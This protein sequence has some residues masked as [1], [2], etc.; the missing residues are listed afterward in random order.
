MFR[1][2]SVGK[3]AG[4]VMTALAFLPTSYASEFDVKRCMNLGN[5][6]DAPSTGA[7]GHIIEQSSLKA[8]A[9][10]GFDTVRIP[11]RWN[12]R[13]G[14]GPDFFISEDFFERVVEVI[15]WALAED[16]NVII[17]VHHFEG[18]NEAPRRHRAQLMKIWEQISTRFK[19]LPPSVYFEVFNEPNGKFEG[20]VMRSYLREAVS[21]IRRTNPDRY[22]ILGGEQWNSIST[23]D[24]IPEINDT[25]IVHTFHYYNP[26]KFTHQKTSWTQ[27]KNGPT[28]YWGTDADKRQV[29][30][31]I[32]GATAYRKRTGRALFAGEFGAYEGAPYKDMIDYLETTRSVLEAEGIGWCVWNFT[33]SFSMYDVEKKA[34]HPDRLWALGM[35]EKEESSDYL[36]SANVDVKPDNASAIG[37]VEIQP[38]LDVEFNQVRRIL[39]K[40]GELIHPPFPD[41]LTAYGN[42]KTRI[43]DDASMPGGKALRVRVAKAGKNPWESGVSGP[44]AGA[45]EKGDALIAV[46]YLKSASGSGQIANAGLQLNSEPYTALFSESISVGSG[47]QRVFLSGVAERDYKNGEAGYFFQVAGQKQTLFMGPLFI[48]NLGKGV[49]RETLP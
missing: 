1:Q 33:S 44:I 15:D 28:T 31:E 7:W 10:A 16:L 40:D 26:F 30:E 6:L 17:D 38:S 48:F 32:K 19:D 8:I 14:D 4:L 42:T 39:P 25:N 34:W 21:I 2:Y 49:A 23:L 35:T 27:L 12:M 20:D 18:I 13:T 43:I 3:I 36:Q 47:V 11:V 45:I 41:Q 29:A 37:A 22:L 5:D 46:V 24:S 9:D